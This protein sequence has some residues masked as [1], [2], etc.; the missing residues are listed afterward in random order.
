MPGFS[1]EVEKQTR[2]EVSQSF[3][4]L[5]LHHHIRLHPSI[6]PRDHDFLSAA[7]TMELFH[8]KKS[9]KGAA[10]ALFAVGRGA[11]DS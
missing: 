2:G 10:S 3:P 6:A 7:Q 1:E 9:S 4:F 11:V 8:L 5:L